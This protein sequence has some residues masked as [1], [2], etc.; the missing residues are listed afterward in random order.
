VAEFGLLAW[1][2]I[3]EIIEASQPCFDLLI[4]LVES[5]LL[6]EGP[7]REPLISLVRVVGVDFGL[8]A[9]VWGSLEV[10]LNPRRLVR[11]L[12]QTV[13][14]FLVVGTLVAPGYPG[15]GRVQATALVVALVAAVLLFRSR[16]V[17]ASAFGS[18][19]Q[20][21]YALLLAMASSI[22]LGAWLIVLVSVS[23][24][25]CSGPVRC[26][27]DL[28]SV[29]LLAPAVVAAGFYLVHARWRATHPLKLDQVIVRLPS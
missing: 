5:F 25:G 10:G 2:P 24:I 6:S 9:F 28:R 13:A 18:P 15:L 29:S 12:V 8:S 23:P 1:E 3:D 19:L 22:V 26:A 27:D 21:P 20:S 7:L 16:H 4:L 14:V 17:L 11:Q